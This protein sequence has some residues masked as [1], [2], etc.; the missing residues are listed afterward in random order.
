[1]CYTGMEVRF[2]KRF[3][4]LLIALMVFLTGCGL[5][6]AQFREMPDENVVEYRDLRY[7]A[8]A[9]DRETYMNLCA[10]YEAALAFEEWCDLPYPMLPA[11]VEALIGVLRCECPELMML[12]LGRPFEMITVGGNVIRLQLHY[13]MDA[14][15]YG[16]MDLQVRRQL[17][18]FAQQC[19]GLTDAEKER[20]IYDYI[21]QNCVYDDT[22]DW[23]GTAFGCLIQGRAKC[24]GISDAM[25]WALE[26]VGVPCITIA[27]M[28]LQ[29]DVG[30]AWNVVC[31]DGIWYDLDVTADVNRE[32]DE[33]ENCYS[34]YNVSD[35]WVRQQYE[36]EGYLADYSPLPGTPNMDGSYHA[37]TGGYVKTGEEDNLE[38]LYKQAYE[39]QGSFIL[40]F[41]SQQDFE[42]FEEDLEAR[43][44]VLGNQ[45]H[46]PSWS[47]ATVS[48]PDYR[49]IHITAGEN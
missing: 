1:M 44:E 3:C 38:Q 15:V 22:A 43:L 36:L 48:V 37:L 27:G 45:Q 25:K 39:T 4:C 49:T 6:P 29:G 20:L 47:W 26:A 13:R 18:E 11:E 7:F 30:H 32:E 9:M 12:D 46:W 23:A 35:S 16:A 5:D 2:M 14:G 28:P 34:A 41:E 8:Q 10:C 33:A 17:K 42:D 40:Q 21:T 19:Q 31:L 24:D